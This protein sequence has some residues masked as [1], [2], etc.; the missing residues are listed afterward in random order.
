MLDVAAG[1]GNAA[2]PAAALGAQ[3]IATDLAPELFVA[4]REAAALACVE[5]DWQ[6]ADAEALPFGDN[7][8]DVV[9]SCV[10][11]M[12]APHHQRAAADE[13]L[14]GMPTRRKDR[15]AEVGLRRGSSARCSKR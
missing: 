2:I 5:L 9:L 8:F 14:R 4:G 15:S 6:E 10:G 12:F 1:S 13:L 3:V 7:E 11:V